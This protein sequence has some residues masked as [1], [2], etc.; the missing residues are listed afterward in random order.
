MSTPRRNG[1]LCFILLNVNTSYTSRQKCLN[2]C[3]S[4]GLSFLL[5]T[6][7]MSS[8]DIYPF[9]RISGTCCP[10]HWAWL[11]LRSADSYLIHGELDSICQCFGSYFLY[12]SLLLNVFIP[13]KTVEKEIDNSARNMSPT[14]APQL[15]T[16]FQHFIIT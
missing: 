1:N 3:W 15:G 16:P 6:L 11:K 13:L 12:G 10:A 4:M 7:I 14:V 5:P 2:Y 8:R 9:S